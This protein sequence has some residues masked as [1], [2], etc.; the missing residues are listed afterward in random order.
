[1]S[2][3]ASCKKILVIMNPELIE[4]S[5]PLES[6]LLK[7]AIAFS[8]DRGCE[9]E[10][11]HVAYD[12]ALEYQLFKSGDEF[13]RL[14]QE[15]LDNDATKL[16]E[17]A[18][19]LV[20]RGIAVEHEVRWDYPR[21]DAILRKVAQS[22]P[23]FVMKRQQ[24]H[25]FFLGIT[26]NT[27]WELARRATANLWLVHDATDRI[28]AL[29][30]AVGNRMG[31]PGDVTAD[32]DHTL[33][34]TAI[35]VGKAC[36]ARVLAVNAYELP[37]VA[38]YIANAGDTMMP[39]QSTRDH[40]KTR[41]RIVARHSEHVRA[42]TDNVGIGQQDIYLREGHPATVI[43]EVA[44]EVGAGLIVMGANSIGRLERIV[45]PV[46]VEPVMANAGCDILIVRGEITDDVPGVAKR[47]AKGEPRYDLE[48][49]ITHPDDTFESP[50][51]VANLS[52]ISVD[53]R[54]RI[55]QAWEYD[56]RA[57]MREQN[58]GGPVREVDADALDQILSAKALLDM[59]TGRG[60]AAGSD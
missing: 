21:A 39:V 7:R 42:L 13:E 6:A 44:K 50:Q 10:L 36:N 57:E 25:G 43:P 51:Q 30:A 2:S 47:T 3:K 14:R 38:N 55:L 45:R 23:D 22:E 56:I 18:A 15:R 32:I 60:A 48:Y 8:K 49:A 53:L 5:D 20:Q 26:T 28:D 40:E 19:W 11:F 31:G 33:L 52:E 9:L 58:E 4:S 12:S 54:K 37:D 24:R 29:I 16:A 35:D 1:M 34:T 41:S 59:K 27:D 17:I 46:T